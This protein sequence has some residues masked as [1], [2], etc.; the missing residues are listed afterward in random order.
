MPNDSKRSVPIRLDSL[1]EVLA[2]R[3]ESE[4]AVLDVLIGGLARGQSNA[5][6]WAMLH[7]AARRDDRVSELAFA[8]ESA[9]GDKKVRLLAAAAQVDLQMHAARFFV[10]DFGDVEGAV[11]HL[12]RVIA[13]APVNA[14]AFERLEAYLV[15]RREDR[16]LAELY[17][18]VAQFRE[19]G[20]QLRLLRRAI[21]IFSG[22]AG[23][24]DRAVKLGRE[25]LRLDPQ[26]RATRSV[27]EAKLVRAGRAGEAARLLEQALVDAAEGD[28]DEALALRTR[29]VT[30]YAGI[31]EPERALPH[32]EEIL[33][34]DPAHEA[35]RATLGALLSNK[36]LA[37]RAA[38]AL[39][40][41]HERTGDL[42]EAVRL[43][44][45]Q[46]EALRG[47]KRLEAQKRLLV[48]LADRLGDA[49]AAFAVCEAV[50]P[51]DPGDEAIRQ[52]LRALAA[53]LGR[54][55][56]AARVMQRA[57]L[58]CRD[59]VLRAGLGAELGELYLE[60]GDVKKARLSLASVIDGG[61]DAG[62]VLRA[63]RALGI[64]CTREQDARGLAAVLQRL[65]E[66]EVDA[67]ARAEA[68]VRL[69]AICE[70]ALADPAGAVAAYRRLF[71]T[72][73]EE[74]AIGALER[75]L[76]GSDD[77][78][79]LAEI[80]DRKA[81]HTADPG[82]AR[83]LAFRA[84]EARTAGAED[85]IAIRAW[86]AFADRFGASR[87]V[88]AR[89]IPLLDR[90]ARWEDLAE[91]LA[92]DAELAPEDER[93]A[94]LGRLGLAR[95][96]RL[97]DPLR[98][99]DA[100]ARALALDPYEKASVRALGALLEADGEVAV[101]AA[102]VL[103]PLLR[104]ERARGDSAAA[105]RGLVRVL[106]AR[107]DAAPLARARLDALAEAASLTAG[108]L[109]DPRAALELAGR[110]LG[111]AMR[112]SML[113]GLGPWLVR[114]DA[115]AVVASEPGRRAVIL[116]GALGD[117]S[118]D[119][120]AVAALARRAAEALAATG[121]EPAAIA[122][123]RRLLAF[124]PRSPD[125]VERIDALLR[126][127]GAPGDRAEVLRG[128][129]A[130]ETDP[131]ARRRLLHLLASLE[132]HELGDLEAAVRT[133]R[134]ALVEDPA[135][136]EAREALLE[137]HLAAGSHDELFDELARGLAG[138]AGDD[139]ARLLCRMA[140]AAAA[141]GRI[142][143]A[144]RCYAEA[145]AA[146]GVALAE[147]ELEA[148]EQ[149]AVRRDDPVLERAV[150][151]RRADLAT[152]EVA[153]V[154]C[155]E[156]LGLLEATRGGDLGAAVRAWKRAAEA[157]TRGAD[158]EA[159]RRLHA[160]VLEV[161]PDDADAAEFLVAAYR[162]GGA[163][164]KLLG[165]YEALARARAG[166]PA[167]VDAVLGL[168]APATIE[169]AVDR[170]VAAADAALAAGGIGDP[171]RVAILTARARVL[172]AAP[173]RED[174]AA[175]AFRGLVAA[176]SEPGDAAR[177]F[178]AFLDRHGL[179]PARIA[180]RR[181]L[182]SWRLDAAAP[183]ERVSCLIRWAEAEERAF[184]DLAAAADL[185]GRVL[186][187]EP[188][189][190]EALGARAR[191][192]LAL[193][194]PEGAL[195]ALVAR[196]E[197]AAGP[198]R[199][200]LSIAIARLSLEPLGRV[201]EA[202]GA[203]EAAMSVAPNDPA[204]IALVEH[205]MTLPAARARA[206]ALLE[207]AAEEGG[208]APTS[209][210]LLRALLAD[211][212]APAED[213]RR[214]LGRLVDLDADDPGS[215][216]ESVLAALRELPGEASLWDR[217]EA[218]ARELDLPVV[219]AE[220]YRHA[221]DSAALGLPDEAFEELGQRAVAFHE[222]WLD[223]P[224]TVAT[225]LRR[226]L[227][228]CPSAT[229]AFD[230]L[231]LFFNA[232]ERWDELFAA[233]DEVIAAS[234][235][236]QRIALLEDAAETA[237]DLAGDVDRAI[238]YL[239]G[240]LP[241]KRE[242]RVT[243]SL[244]RLYERT[245]RHRS[246]VELLSH[247]LAELDLEAAQRLRIRIAGLWLDA[248]DAAAACG[249]LEDAIA[250]EPSRPEVVELLERALAQTAGADDPARRRVAV[251]LVARY[252][253]EGRDVDLARVLEIALSAE[254]EPAARAVLLADLRDLRA[255]LGDDAGALAPSAEL[256]ALEPGVP[257][258]L[259]ELERLAAG[260]GRLDVF[261]D[262]L[263]RIAEARSDGAERAALYARS[264]AL[265]EGPLADPARAAALRRQVMALATDDEEVLASARVL[266][267]LLGS[268]GRGAE[269]C[270]VLER[271]AS[272]AGD[273]VE[274]RAALAEVARVAT[275]A[276]DDARAI[277]AWRARVDAAPEDRAAQVGL[278]E[279]L[280]R[281][282]LHEDLA[283][284]LTR[285]AGFAPDVAAARDDRAAV[286]RL[287]AGPL[288][289]PAEAIEVWTRLREELGPDDASC[290]ALAELLGAAGRGDDLA[291]LLDAS[292]TAATTQDRRVE[293]AR[294]LGDTHR[295]RTRDLDLAV[296]AYG[297]AL[298]DDPGDR[299]ALDG[300][301]AIVEELTRAARPG[302]PP[303]L[304]RSAVDAIVAVQAERDAWDAT[305]RL[306]EPRL[307]VA[308]DDAARVTL[309]LEAGGL[310]EGRAGDPERAFEAV[311]RAFRLSPSG[312][313]GVEVLRL[314]TVADRWADVAEGLPRALEG[315]DPPAATVARDLFSHVGAWARDVRLDPEAA[316]A[317]FARA[318]TRDP[319]NA[320]LL[321]S[322]ADLQRRAPGAALVATLLRLSDAKGGDLALLREAAAVA[323]GPVGDRDRARG[324]AERLLDLATE[325]WLAAGDEGGAPRDAAAWAL[326][327]LIDLADDVADAGTPAAPRS[328][329]VRARLIE[330]H[331]RGASLPFG[332]ADQRR[333]RL[334]A[335]ALADDDRAMDLYRALFE[336]RPE[337]EIVASR[338]EALYRS[339]GRSHELLA[340][341]ERQIALV[342][343]DP[344]AR[345]RLDVA[346]IRA[347]LGEREAAASI[348]RE[349][350]VE[351]PGHEASADRLG[352][353]LAELG[354]NAEL[355]ALLEDRATFAE[356]A[357]DLPRASAAFERAGTLAIERLADPDRGLISLE[358][359]AELGSDPALD[360][361]ARLRAA[362]GDHAAAADALERLCERGAPETVAIALPRLLSSL[363]DA[364]RYA[365][366][367]DRLDVALAAGVPGGD[368]LRGCLLALFRGAAAW[369][370]LADLLAVEAD[371]AADPEAKLAGL[372]EAADLHLDRRSDPAS[373]V[374]L[375]ERAAAVAPADRSVAL[376]LAAALS[377]IGR[378]ADAAEVLRG[379]L[380]SYGAR[381]PR[382]RAR[383]HHE[384][385]RALLA[386]DDRAGALAELDLCL[387][388]DP[389][390]AAAL[391]V[392]AR[393][394]ID[395]GQVERAQRTL[396]ALLLVVKT[397]GAD[398]GVGRAEVLC[399][400]GYVSELS[401]DHARAEEH[402]ESAIELARSDAGE[403]PAILRA[404]RD[405]KRDGA[406]GRALAARLEGAVGIAPDEAAPLFC[407]LSAVEER[408]G[409]PDAAF[410]ASLCA[411]E[412]A[413]GGAAVHQL[414]AALAHRLDRAADYAAALT[415]LADRLDDG[416]ALAAV[417]LHALAVR[418]AEV[419]ASDDRVLGLL[420]RAE[421][422]A[423]SAGVEASAIRCSLQSIY[424]RSG[425]EAAAEALLEQQLAA[426]ALDAVGADVAEAALALAAL[427]MSH[428]SG[429]DGGVP[430]LD[431]ALRAGAAPDR[432]EVAVRQGLAGCPD[433]AA[434]ADLL[435]RI[436]RDHGRP[437]ARLDALVLRA[438]AAA[439][440]AEGLGS[441]ADCHAA[442]AALREAAELA[443]SQGDIASVEGLAAR[444][445]AL[446]PSAEGTAADD[447]DLGWA[448]SDLA[449]VRERAGDRA[450]ASSL[451]ERAA[452]VAAPSERRSLLLSAA[453][454]A[455]DPQ[456]SA[457]IL[458]ELVAEDPSDPVAWSALVAALEHLGGASRVA[459]ATERALA[460][461]SDAPL[462][463]SRLRELARLVGASDPARAAALLEPALGDDPDLDLVAD[464]VVAL[465][466]RAGLDDDLA[467]VLTV[468]V[469]VLAA[470]GDV[471][472]TA[473]TGLLLGAAL[474]R[475]G[476][477]D[478]ALAAYRGALAADPTNLD[479]L[480]AD[481]RLDGG[482]TVDLCEV[483]ARLLATG[484]VLDAAQVALETAAA[485]GAT[486]DE[487]GALEALL[488]GHYACPGSAP[489]LD[490]LV[491][492][493]DARGDHRAVVELHVATA[494]ASLAID[495]RVAALRAGAAV[496]RDR[497]GD[498]H[499]AVELLLEAHAIT[500]D[501]RALL[502]ALVD[503]CGAA[504]DHRR[505]LAALS[506]AI[507]RSP[508]D[509]ALYRLR[510]S[511]HDAVGDEDEALADLERA[512]DASHG[513]HTL[514]LVAM[515][516][517]A[518]EVLDARPLSLSVPANKPRSTVPPVRASQPP[519]EPTPGPPPPWSA[520]VPPVVSFDSE[521]ITATGVRPM[522]TRPKAPRANGSAIAVVVGPSRERT[523]RL[524]FAEVLVRSGDVDRARSQLA[525]LLHA[526]PAD[527]DAL[528]AAALLEEGARRWDAATGLYRRLLPLIEGDALADIALRLADTSE[529]VGRPGDAR[530][531]LE[532]AL[533]FGPPRPALGLR[534]R[535]IDDAIA[536][537]DGEWSANDVEALPPDLA[538][539]FA[540]LVQA[541]RRALEGDLAGDRAVAP[542]EEAQLLRPDD[543]DVAVLLAEAYVEADRRADAEIL[544]TR[545]AGQRMGVR[546]RAIAAI[547]R[548]R[549]RLASEDGADDEA[550]VAIT[551]AF[552]CDPYDPAIGVELAQRAID[553][554]D[555]DT[556]R[557]ALDAVVNTRRAGDGAGRS[558]APLRARALHRLAELAISDGDRALARS[559]LEQALREDPASDG[560]RSTLAEIDG[561]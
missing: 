5:E 58:V 99:V 168:E 46:V 427:R 297:M 310:H 157:A 552:V 186:A 221:I 337:D 26:D 501:D 84:A 404:L 243:A 504:G 450:E 459:L 544:A 508:A 245:G 325:R 429:V 358:R 403:W 411:V 272:I 409:R 76:A 173:G 418:L 169:G 38:A 408:L 260:V 144:G 155:L 486:G 414:A 16:R 248:G 183:A 33:R 228:R 520:P 344:R 28:A 390:H 336:E 491:A 190:D 386:A 140:E 176:A 247:D 124:D 57:N 360:A 270:E 507:D 15:E 281:L 48:L 159:A 546:S 434:L 257:S 223:E 143:D 88:Y 201:D 558:V 229:W 241:W 543:D 207:R 465:L 108:E 308:A 232:A 345:L 284:A 175:A 120:P 149:V 233:Y 521:E 560:A 156:R 470:R 541:G 141:G 495:E 117:R 249:V 185:H 246:L 535:A 258:H 474:E 98:A 179:D 311:W 435:A 371:L 400:L 127:H 433:H 527:A 556:G 265:Y 442:V 396:R 138:A 211:P 9:L 69:A 80:L 105:T 319:E 514:E 482:G 36:A 212:D 60:G 383:F 253:V 366:A 496:L 225:I 130:H 89:L 355:V 1:A 401:G 235:V 37:V 412:A 384:L 417:A 276:G 67:A 347:A 77:L 103:E 551:E 110:G 516:E 192:L 271:I 493:Y 160:R 40:G 52:R 304:L 453:S 413:P 517:H 133:Y 402:L 291:A 424:A 187:I 428:P 96:E 365:D 387:R 61:A 27:I 285:R 331:L 469:A 361:V 24:D 102:D 339:A 214:W 354:R 267:Q 109:A 218:L 532:R 17:A 23:E 163:P 471:P 399:E 494:A 299:G 107:A 64:L 320:E 287:L 487:D 513:E 467:R 381:R 177:A 449:R 515:L 180:D 307:L 306:L 55:L 489:L 283:V 548:L 362:R 534:L 334:D 519:M 382:D 391:S 497:V 510:A 550:L 468:R 234:P 477:T 238:R 237:R 22:I 531:G 420:R 457:T 209:R 438:E 95:L 104:A 332:A 213:R 219:V 193:G 34:V 300:L 91:T 518:L 509:G 59:V 322:V 473:A 172:A 458:E 290:D 242:A 452:R 370:P 135:D 106:L 352:Q 97:G 380:A 171:G 137:A 533:A 227:A 328:P 101:A 448:L 195:A 490:A 456:R 410:S 479:A 294:R 280:T 483:I 378:P 14:E 503:A 416:G 224:E 555:V 11:P 31:S 346:E 349:S 464:E 363:V 447:A 313:A 118:I 75:L 261:A 329:D 553:V 222:E 356:R 407:E 181:W 8:Y 178:E 350:L 324:I 182:L 379:I 19:R 256:A 476:R 54:P 305:L 203:L 68:T 368:A 205:A 373:A 277:R 259:A 398:A 151:E 49:D 540:L 395:D 119:H 4:A 131:E 372:R 70:G 217:A 239:E 423:V 444:A 315:R 128:A 462:R 537:A 446:L 561:G 498:V 174:D 393:L 461:L 301:E 3:H 56:D 150:L 262:T 326:A 210:R 18:S 439:K 154:A 240:L 10:D 87:A 12:E 348:L 112:S 90:A 250:L 502:E 545:V 559:L 292:L 92:A 191:L 512:N 549:A 252:R 74:E 288:G 165:A 286:A 121:A 466:G 443:A 422:R 268:L 303:P 536:A 236:D 199:A 392:Q 53:Q 323:R 340:L 342:E 215:A 529:R 278:V 421:Q 485:R 83:D 451:W 197:G 314:A 13:L 153:Q 113:E 480:R 475:L 152:D 406:L 338:L 94:L 44:A 455:E 441:S 35:A 6:L 484:A 134:I 321:A 189:H 430:L 318:L 161:R 116:A 377:S 542:L 216:L 93:A 85:E 274:R 460:S 142:D 170:F 341:R 431:R 30:I 86:R 126:A 166:S 309:L 71:D 492:R 73:H 376:T 269:R 122:V 82:A 415:A 129:L 367:R 7:A 296:L 312:A 419:G 196:R 63:S 289:R 167:V 364:G 21:Q 538:E 65:G 488:E 353:L 148:A 251:L 333:M 397:A 357:G 375:L 100:F 32:A 39:E 204:A 500:P 454:R 388:I 506:V 436:G 43:L 293:L 231:K 478:G 445:L 50:V 200:S 47:P 374:P 2:E 29:L 266:E 78:L 327:A 42:A 343:G 302:A 425:D 139:R 164:A 194:D 554:G 125:V 405:R 132:R 230:R 145:L 547:H 45:L 81:L 115:F 481:L 522:P 62:A 72:P 198:A 505:A 275:E 524:R 539:R 206:S 254:R 530:A 557:R 208:D 298:G 295:L 389:A 316:E 158:D 123:Y 244:E 114:V 440:R 25:V 525:T 279:A 426:F 369:G 526:D 20:E 264:A 41:A 463:V 528:H 472:A 394:A 188:A 66:I 282:G 511:L 146:P 220:A 523:L 499:G 226:V 79:A 184:G 263:S 351:R 162:G 385:A 335:A 136:A 111:E 273:P 255:K 147:S 437:R 317:A 432:V 202:L 330:L 51:V 359:A